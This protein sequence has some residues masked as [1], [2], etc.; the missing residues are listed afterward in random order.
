MIKNL[1][2]PENFISVAKQCLIQGFDLVFAD[3]DYL[4]EDESHERDEY[5]KYH[6]GDLNTALILTYQAI[7]FLLKAEVCRESPLLLLDQNPSDWPTKPDSNDKDFDDLYTINGEGL[8]R[9]YSASVKGKTVDIKLIEFI[10]EV[11]I[12]RN[13]VMHGASKQELTPEYIIQIILDTFLHFLGENSFWDTTR[14]LLINNP[15]FGSFDE[16]FEEADFY[17]RLDYTENIIGQAKFQKHF[18][19]R[20]DCRRYYCPWCLE[21]LI[22]HGEEIQSK[23]GFLQPQ[24]TQG[25]NIIKCLNCRNETEVIRKK[26]TEKDCKG[27]VIYEGDDET[28]CLTCSNEQE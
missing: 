20:L 1:P 2:K 23:W 17:R 8:V 22:K 27:D 15:M 19:M 3:D 21:A 9:K 10:E 28:L 24:R 4:R 25:A 18:D 7:E 14:D 5:W 16:D 11:R 13:K 26:C 12:V 6:I